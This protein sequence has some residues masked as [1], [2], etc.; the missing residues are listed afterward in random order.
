VVGERHIGPVRNWQAHQHSSAQQKNPLQVRAFR[1]V[2]TAAVTLIALAGCASDP[3]AEDYLDGGNEGFISGTGITEIPV[4]QRGDPI[5]FEGETDT[6]ETVSRADYEGEVLV[7][8]FWY[9]ECAPCRVEAPDLVALD[10]KYDNAGADFLGVNVYNSAPRSRAFA[11]TFDVRY[12]SVLDATDQKV[13]LAF[14][15]EVAPNAVPTTFVLDTR[16]RIAARII[17][18]V[19]ARSILDTIIR[20]VIAENR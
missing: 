20:D 15:G 7:V 9:A 14:A 2:A 3:L 17:G 16:G 4:N 12:P 18:Q 11:E 10:A 13:R 1:A 6:G 19:E 5:S 8:N